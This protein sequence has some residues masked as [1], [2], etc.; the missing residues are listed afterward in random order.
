MLVRYMDTVRERGI[1]CSYL[2]IRQGRFK[3][4][5]VCQEDLA[6]EIQR[7]TLKVSE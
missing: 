5:M 1:T 2:R 6:I 4:W 3:G 7:M